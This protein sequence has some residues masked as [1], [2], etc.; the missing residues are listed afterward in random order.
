MQA[1]HGC[2]PLTTIQALKHTVSTKWILLGPVTGHQST[3]AWQEHVP[4]NSPR[5]QIAVHPIPAPLQIYPKSFTCPVSH[6]PQPVQPVGSLALGGHAHQD[7]DAFVLK[8]LRRDSNLCPMLGLYH[9]STQLRTTSLCSPPLSAA[10]LAFFSFFFFFFSFLL[11]SS[12]G[13]LAG[14][15]GLTVSSLSLSDSR[16]LC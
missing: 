13:G 12:G 7:A 3:E 5:A 4:M 10:S 1:P 9:G 16:F 6:H 15:G 8:A 11:S 2:N 14:D